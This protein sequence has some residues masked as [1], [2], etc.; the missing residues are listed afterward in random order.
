MS[1]YDIFMISMLCAALIVWQAI[2][3]MQH[4]RKQRRIKLRNSVSDLVE[5]INRGEL[6]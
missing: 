3:I 2:S 5:R 1:Q 4:N 6:K